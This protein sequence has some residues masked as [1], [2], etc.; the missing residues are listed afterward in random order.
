LVYSVGLFAIGY[1]SIFISLIV[2]G[3]LTPHIL[4]KIH[5]KHYPTLQ[6]QNGND[7]IFLGILKL[8]KTIFVTI[9]LLIMLFPFY[10][11]PIVNIVAINLP[12]Y[13]MFHKLLNYDVS[14]N[15]MKT[16]QFKRLYYVYKNRLRLKT[17]LLYSVS[18]IPFVA[19]FISIFY[20]IYIGHTYFQILE[21]EKNGY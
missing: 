14:S 3:F 8:L 7:N 1:L 6:I 21:K 17:L 4:S 20:V 5:K 19:F 10:F 2:V 18:L 13:Y 11:I 12:F 16:E 9:L 15:I